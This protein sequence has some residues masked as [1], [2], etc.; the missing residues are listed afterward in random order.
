MQCFLEGFCS[1]KAAKVG[2][3][4]VF[5]AHWVALAVAAAAAGLGGGAVWR[6]AGRG[7]GEGW[8]SGSDV[9]G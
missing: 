2:G 5:S 6:H 1:P 7:L 3:A 4:V 9:V 8:R